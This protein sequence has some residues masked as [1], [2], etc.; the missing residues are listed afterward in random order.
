MAYRMTVCGV[1]AGAIWPRTTGR[2]APVTEPREPT[3]AP[4]RPGASTLEE[5]RP[6]TAEEWGG[7]PGDGGPPGGTGGGGGGS[8]DGGPVGN[9]GS[10]E[11]KKKKQHQKEAGAQTS[12]EAA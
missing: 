9:S 7:G 6:L 5:P 12:H 2:D 1:G 8:G 4:T 3:P 11:P 10:S